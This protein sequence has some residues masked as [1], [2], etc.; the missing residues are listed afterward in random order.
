MGFVVLV[1]RRRQFSGLKAVFAHRA[2]I[3]GNPE[4]TI[5]LTIGQAF[6]EVVLELLSSFATP[7]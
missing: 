7:V 2:W 3:T 4:I 1:A 6:E 5:W